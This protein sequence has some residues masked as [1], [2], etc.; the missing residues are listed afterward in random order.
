MLIIIGAI[1]EALGLASGAILLLDV[2]DA[3]PAS[4]GA[5]TWIMFP[6]L[7]I[8]GYVLMVLAPSND[9]FARASSWTGGALLM[10]GL[11]AVLA[12]FLAANGLMPLEQ[13]TAPL[14]YVALVGFTLG[15]VAFGVR[16]VK[17]PPQE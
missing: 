7:C 2:F 17:L 16:R 1:F 12:L 13:S 10:L 8:A 3:I 15:S 4:P 5:Q 9:G 6:G 11:A 14:W